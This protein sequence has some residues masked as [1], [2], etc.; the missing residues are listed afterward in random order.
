M[1]KVADE[2]ANLNP[3]K[4]KFSNNGLTRT[5]AHIIEADFVL[6]LRKI[7]LLAKG[8]DCTQ[9]GRI[10]NGAHPIYLICLSN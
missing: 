10:P 9:S 8:K 4:R 7:G 6:K 5:A 3:G 1:G 2:S